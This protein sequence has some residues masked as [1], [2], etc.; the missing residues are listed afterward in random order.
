VMGAHERSDGSGHPLG[1]A[2]AA[3]RLDLLL[4]QAV[5]CYVERVKPWRQAEPSSGLAALAWLGKLAAAGRL[6]E[7]CVQALKTPPPDEGTRRRRDSPMPLGLTAREREVLRHLCLGQS[8]KQIAK[9]LDISPKTVGTHVERLYAKLAV[10]TRAAATIRAL[11][12]GLFDPDR[13]YWV[14][15]EE[16]V[17][18]RST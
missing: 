3:H 14:G 9:A 12:A 10:S 17:S 5:V 15:H 11:Q 18:A 6:D 1:M 13:P 4:L 8:N 7:R 16:P 2:T